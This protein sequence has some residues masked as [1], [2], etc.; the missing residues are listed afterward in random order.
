[1]SDREDESYCVSAQVEESEQ[2]SYTD[3]IQV[4]EHEQPE[5]LGDAVIALKMSRDN[6][7]DYDK[8]DE[9]KAHVVNEHTDWK[10]ISNGVYVLAFQNQMH[11]RMQ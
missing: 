1:M 6:V 5:Q 10:K 2:E 4:G 7:S 9:E 3:S 8:S 11:L